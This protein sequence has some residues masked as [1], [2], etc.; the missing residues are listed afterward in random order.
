MLW[1]LRQISKHLPVTDCTGGAFF[2]LATGWRRRIFELFELST[3]RRAPLNASPAR[4][5][6]ASSTIAA[7]SNPSLV[8]CTAM[9]PKNVIFYYCLSRC[10]SLSLGLLPSPTF[11]FA[12]PSTGRLLPCLPKRLQPRLPAEQEERWA[13]CTRER[14][15]M[16]CCIATQPLSVQFPTSFRKSRQCLPDRPVHGGRCRA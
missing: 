3:S 11:L 7:P 5:T 2:E 16:K 4:P 6:S 9:R 10:F 8:F 13:V 1:L 14:G 12:C 15:E